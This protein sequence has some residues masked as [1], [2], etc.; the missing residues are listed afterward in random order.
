MSAECARATYSL[1]P[2]S[3]CCAAPL[4]YEQSSPM[5]PL[6][7]ARVLAAAGKPEDSADLFAVAI[8]EARCAGLCRAAGLPGCRA[9]VA[10]S[11]FG[12]SI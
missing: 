7:V 1:W 10:G 8:N 9:A 3:P 5:R 11:R 4:L 12:H 2:P 6:G